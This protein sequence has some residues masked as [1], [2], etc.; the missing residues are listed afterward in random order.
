MTCGRPS[1][2]TRCADVTRGTSVWSSEG[3]GLDEGTPVKPSRGAWP[4]RIAMQALCHVRTG[5]DWPLETRNLEGR[6]ADPANR[7]FVRTNECFCTVHPELFKAADGRAPYSSIIINIPSLVRES[8]W[9]MICRMR[10]PPT[11]HLLCSFQTETAAVQSSRGQAGV[12]SPQTRHA[13]RH[14]NREGTEDAR[15]GHEDA[16]PFLPPSSLGWPP[17]ALAAILG[18]S[19]HMGRPRAGAPADSQHQWPACEGRGLR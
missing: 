2:A 11:S 17:L 19:S 3:T 13:S 16:T 8:L 6:L 7:R 14:L 5:C 4:A 15:P 9:Q 10:S 18:G 12:P 1:P